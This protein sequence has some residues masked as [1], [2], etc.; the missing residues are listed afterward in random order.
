GIDGDTVVSHG[1]AHMAVLARAG[2]WFTLARE[3]KGFARNFNRSPWKLMWKHVWYG[4]LRPLA[5]EPL[6]RFRRIVLGRHPSPPCIPLTINQ[7]FAQR[8]A[9]QERMQALTEGRS[10]AALTERD[11]HYRRLT[12]GIHSFYF[13]VADKAAAA[14]CVEPRYPFFDKRLVEF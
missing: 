3:V 4:G 6:R 2:R 5:P 1:V 12:A 14:F 8:I 9:L 13:E 7:R 10:G 11:D